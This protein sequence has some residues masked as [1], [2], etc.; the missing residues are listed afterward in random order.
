[1]M[2]VLLGGC[3]LDVIGTWQIER[4]SVGDAVVEDAG[5]ID[6]RNNGDVSSGLPQAVLLRYTWDPTEAAWAPDPTPFIQT[7]VFDVFAFQ[8]DPG[9][10]VFR[11]EFPLDDTAST[12]SRAE[13][14]PDVPRAGTW[15]LEDPDW[16]H[17]AL[18]LSLVR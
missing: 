13:F 11:L 8:D 2:L 14:Y 1:M 7:A 3:G 9:T 5:F 6:V 18:E 10:A 17:G 15:L 16:E 12:T 4:A